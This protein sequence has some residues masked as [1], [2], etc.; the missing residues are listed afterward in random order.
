MDKE[1]IDHWIKVFIGI[2]NYSRRHYEIDSADA[3]QLVKLLQELRDGKKEIADLRAEKTETWAMFKASELKNVGL[4]EQIADQRVAL[5]LYE[6]IFIK[7]EN[8]CKAY[9]LDVF[10]EPEDWEEIKHVLQPHGI[11]LDAISASNMRHVVNGIQDLIKP[12]QEALR[13]D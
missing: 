6:D 4:I 13:G 3:R 2:A 8:W 7:I 10:P 5:E 12:A 1:P 9:P 11:S